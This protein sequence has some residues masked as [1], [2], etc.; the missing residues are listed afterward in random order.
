MELLKQG[1]RLS[2]QP[3]SKLEFEAIL[4]MSKEARSEPK[5]PAKKKV[6]ARR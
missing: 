6:A 2:V 4:A 1:S 3:V 5:K